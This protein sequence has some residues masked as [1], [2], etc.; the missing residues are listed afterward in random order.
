MAVFQYEAADTQGVLL[1]GVIEA[2]SV[3][4]ANGLLKAQGLLPLE[5]NPAVA[6]ASSNKPGSAQKAS[7]L[8]TVLW[9]KA[10]FSETDRTLLM[11]QLSSLVQARLPLEQAL[12]ALLAQT[13][14]Q[15]GEPNPAQEAVLAAVRSRV[16]EGASLSVA[17]ANFPKEFPAETTAMIAAGEASGALPLV[18]EKLADYLENRAALRQKMV[19]S[20]A[21][22]IIVACVAVLMIIGLMTYVVPQIVGVF[23]NAKQSLPLLTTVMIVISNALRSY[24]LLALF[25]IVM[26]V[27]SFRYALKN[28]AF[29]ARWHGWLLRAPLAGRLIALSQTERFISTLAILVAGGVPLLRALEAAQRTLTNVVL[30][31]RIATAAVRVREGAPLSKALGQTFTPMVAH[32]VAS[33]ESTGR[34]SE[35]LSRA[36]TLQ[37][38]ELERRLGL[39]TTILEPA[40]ILGMGVLVLVIVLAVLLPIIEINQ[41]VK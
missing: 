34:L 9:A 27:F 15:S 29:Q 19:A 40:I 23:Q 37:G 36:A 26:A 1:H 3:R 14:I 33:G 41:L 12:S 2:D 35:M 5:V 38:R 8:N 17:M 7:G 13:Q 6:S 25:V 22:P 31:N 39:M 24:G 21:Y 16:M 32:L 28:A 30:A 4:H 11:R 18:L 20:L 10:A